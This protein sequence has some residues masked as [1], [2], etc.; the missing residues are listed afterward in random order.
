MPANPLYAFCTAALLFMISAAPAAAAP[1]I[2]ALLATEG[3]VPLD[4][5]NGKCG[6]EF[7]GFC[8]Q[9]KRPDPAPGTQ[10][11]AAGGDVTLVITRADGTVQRLPADDY[12]S[13]ETS[14][15]YTAVRIT[16]DEAR[17][18]EWDAVSLALE[19][20]ERVALVPVPEGMDTDPQ[21]EADVALALGPQRALGERILEESPAETG[22]VRLTGRMIGALPP[23][24]TDAATR[25]TLWD[26]VVAPSAAAFPPAA[27]SR[28]GSL[29]QRCLA[30][31]EA[32][33]FYSLRNCLKIGH[34]ALMIDL[35]VKYWQAGPES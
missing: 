12:V 25:N 27:V 20:G 9:R 18:A 15:S 34:D 33:S 31:V 22:A 32:G 6:A 11:R 8:L 30:K 21:T 3:A 29:Y 7:S 19:V 4:C 2:L 24:R 14:R 5:R 10:Y 26:R 13:I 28:A 17:L 35:N 23:G 16:V 1:Q